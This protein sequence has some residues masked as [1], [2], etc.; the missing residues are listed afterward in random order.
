M[1]ATL[2]NKGYSESNIAK[3]SGHQSLSQIQK[4]GYDAVMKNNPI[5]KDKAIEE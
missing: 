3:L 5:I 1:C 4:Y 2:L